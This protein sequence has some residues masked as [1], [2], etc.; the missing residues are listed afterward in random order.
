M[1]EHQIPIEEEAHMKKRLYGKLDQYQ[2]ERTADIL[3]FAVLIT[4][5]L[6]IVIHK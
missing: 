4:G 2:A 3:L 5:L 6:A 1:Y